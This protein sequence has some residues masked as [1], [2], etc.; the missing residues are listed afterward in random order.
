[1]KIRIFTPIGMI[2]CDI[3]DSNA[4]KYHINEYCEEIMECFR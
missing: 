2:E 4:E 3:S 1:M